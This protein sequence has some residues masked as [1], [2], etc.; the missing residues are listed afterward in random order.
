MLQES[1]MAFHCFLWPLTILKKVMSYYATE[2]NPCPCCFTEFE[3]QI[4]WNA[5]ISLDRRLVPNLSATF[6]SLQSEKSWC[7]IYITL[8]YTSS[9]R[10]NRNHSWRYRA[11]IFSCCFTNDARMPQLFHPLPCRTS[12]R[13]HLWQPLVSEQQIGGGAVLPVDELIGLG[14]YVK[15][16][17]NFLPFAEQ[18]L[19][20]GKGGVVCSFFFFAFAWHCWV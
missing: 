6:P 15:S 20:L 9:P 4:L 16:N 14:V 8:R 18:Q 17:R 7:N 13:T 1:G 2:K 3:F 12:G 11:T 10:I 19:F 5:Y